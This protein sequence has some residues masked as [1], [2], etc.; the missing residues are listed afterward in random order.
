[1]SLLRR[2]VAESDQ[3]K[4]QTQVD[5][6]A[7]RILQQIIFEVS[8]SHSAEEMKVDNEAMSRVVYDILSSSLKEIRRSHSYDFQSLKTVFYQDVF[9]SIDLSDFAVVLNVLNRIK[10]EHEDS[11]RIVSLQKVKMDSLIRSIF[12]EELLNVSN[13]LQGTRNAMRYY[14]SLISQLEERS[15]YIDT[16]LADFQDDLSPIGSGDDLNEEDVGQFQSVADKVLSGIFDS[17]E[18]GE[19]LR[20]RIR[21][22]FIDLFLTLPSNSDIV[23]ALRLHNPRMLSEFMRPMEFKM[24]AI[25]ARTRY[26]ERLRREL[27]YQISRP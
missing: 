7:S 11:S 12:N 17:S 19:S 13:K 16:I 5:G 25:I 1:M 18:S 3:L 20:D 22:S 21:K 4:P 10:I 6:I 14:R 9:S 2:L 8:N 24:E 15:I 27:W 26:L 23:E